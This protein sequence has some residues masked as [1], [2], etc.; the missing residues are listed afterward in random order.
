MGGGVAQVIKSAHDVVELA[1]Q[2]SDFVTNGIKVV[3]KVGA[4]L[5]KAAFSQAADFTGPPQ[6]PTA[7][8]EKALKAAEGASGVAEV[9]EKAELPVAIAIGAAKT[10]YE[11]YKGDYKEAACTAA[12][13]AAAVA[14]GI[15]GAEVG[16]AT[17]A[18]IGSVVPILG[19]AIGGAVGGIVGGVVGGAMAYSAG[20]DIGKQAYDVVKEGAIGARGE[21]SKV[22]NWFAGGNTSPHA[23]P[24]AAQTVAANNTSTQKINT[25][26]RV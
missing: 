3:G 26:P 20:H 14:G 23:A 9:V 15:A 13:T 16:A 21:L 7:L 12:G 17:G 25:S 5:I 6:A 1:D 2:S 19:T 22:Y 4:P 10:G 11:I 24:A 8:A 18:A